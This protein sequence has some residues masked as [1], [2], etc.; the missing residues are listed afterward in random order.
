MRRYTILSFSALAL[1]AWTAVFIIGTLE[2]YWHQSLAPRGDAQAFLDAAASEIDSLHRGNAVLVLIDGGQVYGDHF[3]S[4]GELID[5]NTVF[6]V[7]SLSKWI[8][9]WGIMTLI[10]AGKLDLDEP[11]LTYLTR[12][13]L[14]G[15]RAS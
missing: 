2:G 6:Q 5:R 10:E 4:V 7:A 1:A 12:W 11:V 9:A 14:P 8:T 15:R 13:K 3:V